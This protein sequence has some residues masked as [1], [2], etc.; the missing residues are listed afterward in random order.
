LDVLDEYLGQHRID[1]TLF[2]C[3]PRNLEYILADIGVGAG[4]DKKPSFEMLRWMAA[5]R[6]Y[7]AGMDADAIRE[8]LGLSKISW[9]ET[10]AKIKRLA[11]EDAEELDSDE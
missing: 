10:F 8:K 3:T 1:E 6:D 9:V 4:L 5:L 7:Q 11:G 2:T